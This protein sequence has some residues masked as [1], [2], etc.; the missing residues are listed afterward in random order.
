MSEHKQ[1]QIIVLKNPAALA[2]EAAS[3]F[4]KLACA[5][6][7]ANGRFSVA[8]SGGSTPR[9]MHERL[10]QPP[11]KNALDWKKVHVFWGDERFVPP[12]DPESNFSMARETLL[13]HVPIPAQNIYPAPTEGIAPEEAARQYAETLKA[14]FAPGTPR[15]DLILL[16]L[17]LDG[18]TASLFPGR[19]QVQASGDS[20]IA[21]V[22]NSPKPPPVRITFTLKLI[23]N[24]A[25]VIF[26]AAGKEKAAAVKLVLGE[27][28]DVITRPAQGVRLVDGKLL[29]LLDSAAARELQ[30]S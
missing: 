28:V 8:L 23:N 7:E 22:K 3:R 11:H 21:A 12:D 25:N 14:F 16:G 10:A 6:V 26:L 13:K 9:A 4:V 1:R 24:A 27:T 19:P 5:A 2:E 17:G 30:L 15:L 18:H 20:L 29:W